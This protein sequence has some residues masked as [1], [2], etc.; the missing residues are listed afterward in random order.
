MADRDALIK[1]FLR[2]NAKR[3]P[4]GPPTWPRSP[5]QDSYGNPTTKRPGDR[6]TELRALHGRWRDMQGAR[7]PRGTKD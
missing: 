4:P 5:R 1:G 3:R 2:R 7:K 6:Q